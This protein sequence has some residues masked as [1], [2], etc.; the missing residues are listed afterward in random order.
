MSFRSDLYQFALNTGIT[1]DKILR[2]VT[3]DFTSDLI[4]LTPVD[5]GLARSSW[6]FSYD[7]SVG[8]E[9]TP[10]KNG[11]PSLRRCAD[12][13]SGLKAGETFW[14][15]NNVPYILYLE[16][17]TEKMKPFAMARTTA[18]NWDGKVRKMAGGA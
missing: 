6:F 9:T 14:I 13:T 7:K 2:K 12:F 16:Y 1:M 10:S 18:D 4:R 11:A 3:L 8:E 5:T 15:T 17:G